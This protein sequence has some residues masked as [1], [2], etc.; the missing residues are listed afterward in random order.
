VIAS[1][2]DTGTEDVFHGRSTARTRSYP[3]D[4][5]RAAARKLDLIDA[6][7]VT[8]DRRVLPGNHLE[9]LKGDLKGK[10]SIRINGQ[11]RIVFAWKDGAAHEVKIVDYH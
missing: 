2:G 3:A 10:H 4:V 8:E 7:H 9:A 6:A 11:W 1:F 5:T